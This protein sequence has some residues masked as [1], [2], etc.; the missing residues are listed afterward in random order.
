[1]DSNDIE[2]IKHKEIWLPIV[3]D[4]NAHIFHIFAILTPRRDELE[5]Y[6]TENGIQTVIHYP[7]P[8]HKQ[9]CYQ[10]LNKFFLPITEQIH[11]QE[12]SL[13]MSPVLSEQDLKFIVDTI[14]KW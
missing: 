3:T 6:L 8:P 14:N 2:N 10:E 1:M 12:L 9:N 7:I 11:N 5:K 13:P 4:W